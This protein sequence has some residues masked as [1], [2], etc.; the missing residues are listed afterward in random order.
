MCGGV[1]GCV[2][3]CGVRGGV[4]GCVGV[5][6]GVWGVWGVWGCLGVCGGV[7][8]CVGVCRGVWRCVGVCGGVLGDYVKK[9]LIL[10]KTKTKG[11]QLRWNNK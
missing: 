4:L 10:F 1:L 7:W 2:G 6:W 9:L 11:L 5:C 3:V 8:G